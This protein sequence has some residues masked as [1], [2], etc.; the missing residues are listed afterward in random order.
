MKRQINVVL[1]QG[2]QFSF[3]VPDGAPLTH[4]TARAWLDQ[5]FAALGCEPLRAGGKVLTADKVL[6]VTRAAGAVLLGDPKW[7][8]DYAAAVGAALG[9]PLVRVD[10]PT[11]V[12]TY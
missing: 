8:A 5:Q 10:V 9:K 4:D 6:A 2:V 11:M 7:S 12:I 3:Q 1:G